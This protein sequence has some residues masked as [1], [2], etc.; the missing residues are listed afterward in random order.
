[1]SGQCEA[2]ELLKVPLGAPDILVRMWLCRSSLDTR[3][4]CGQGFYRLEVF[5]LWL[6]Q[7]PTS[8]G[9][10]GAGSDIPG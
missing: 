3:L 10:A 2:A 5:S 7:R 1:M 4:V 9:D 8:G 6:D